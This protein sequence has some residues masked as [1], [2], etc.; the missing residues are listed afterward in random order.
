MFILVKVKGK[1]IKISFGFW[2]IF[3]WYLNIKVKIIILVIKE[4]KILGKI[5]NKEFLN[6]FFFL[7]V[8]VE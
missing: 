5:I 3:V 1:E 4:I 7:G 8:K 2:D 6:R